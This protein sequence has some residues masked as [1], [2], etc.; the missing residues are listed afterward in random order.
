MKLCVSNGIYFI[1]LQYY[2]DYLHFTTSTMPSVMQNWEIQ[3]I[4]V[5]FA[6]IKIEL[7]FQI[8]KCPQMNATEPYWW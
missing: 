5:L 1:L 3:I 2:I 6:G 8:F 7:I 4:S